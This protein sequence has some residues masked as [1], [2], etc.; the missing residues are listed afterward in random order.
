MKKAKMCADFRSRCGKEEKAGNW[1]GRFLA[2]EIAPEAVFKHFSLRMRHGR[3]AVKDV[4]R[5]NE[6]CLE[7]HDKGKIN[8]TTVSQFTLTP[9]R[10]G[11]L[12]LDFL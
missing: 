3:D 6:R 12:M 10:K 4:I 7:D 9:G 1:M 8:K 11:N 5:G 2:P